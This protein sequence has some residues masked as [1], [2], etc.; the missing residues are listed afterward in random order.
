MELTKTDKGLTWSP[1][2]TKL[3]MKRGLYETL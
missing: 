1:T 3:V 2:D